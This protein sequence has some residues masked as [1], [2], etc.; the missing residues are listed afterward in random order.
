MSISLLDWWLIH[1]KEW[2]ASP[3]TSVGMFPAALVLIIVF[4][5]TFWIKDRF[6]P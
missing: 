2:G 5:V 1:P 4:A 6:W 3:F